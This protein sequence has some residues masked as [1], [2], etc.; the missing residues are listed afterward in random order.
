MKK[1]VA[2]L[3]IIVML[4]CVVG[5]GGKT[6]QNSIINNE[7]FANGYFTTITKWNEGTV[8]YRIIYANDTN[9]KY[10]VIYG[11]QLYAITP[12]YNADSTLQIYGE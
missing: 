1:I 2:I 7:D 6:Y 4:C 10:L 5:C 11:G 3:L 8:N 9:V 12:L